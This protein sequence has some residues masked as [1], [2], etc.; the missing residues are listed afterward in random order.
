[1][2]APARYLAALLAASVVMV[3]G[4]ARSP[5]GSSAPGQLET[6]VAG[7]FSA[8]AT[9]ASP[10]PPPPT[11]TGTPTPLPPT[12]TPTPGPPVRINFLADATTTEVIGRIQA[13]QVRSFVFRAEQGQP[14]LIQ[15]GSLDPAPAF[16]I[17]TQGGTSIYDGKSGQPIWRGTLPQTEDYYLQLHGGD[18]AR[19]FAL[20]VQLAEK[21][22]FREGVS[23]AAVRG[24][25]VG[26][27]VMVYSVLG[28][29]GKEMEVGLSDASDAAALSI[30]GY[31]DGKS[32]LEASEGKKSITLEDLPVT[33]DY[34]VEVVPSDEQV[35]SYLLSVQLQ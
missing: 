3:G 12:A 18:A 29:K 25:T 19:D 7:T 33:Q 4:C 8:A 9:A 16:S 27:S 5:M 23:Y 11:P 6:I 32:Y 30:Y 2:S 17:R 34:I 22:S 21:I 26:G 1:M 24:Q 15:L 35:V 20:R 28:L 14:L 10:T 31:V 13:G